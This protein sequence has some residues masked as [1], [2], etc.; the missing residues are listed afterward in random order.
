MAR[1]SCGALAAT[2]LIPRKTWPMAA[3]PEPP[4]TNYVRL[5]DADIAYQVL[6]DG[7]LDLIY[8]RG[9]WHVEVLWEHPASADF[10]R[11]L[12]SFSRLVLFDR[13]GWGVSDPFPQGAT[14]TWE[15]WAED[16]AAV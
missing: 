5:G 14:P 1:H 2:Q 7:P 16:I 12:A 9:T 11:G 10:L 15:G 13:R 3:P 6:G 4:Q 8:C